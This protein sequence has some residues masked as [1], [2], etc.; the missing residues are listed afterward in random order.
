[1]LDIIRSEF[2]KVRKSKVT[3]VT[4]LCLLGIAGL[5]IAVFLYAKIKGGV[6][7]EMLEGT[8]GLDVYF[9]FANGWKTF[10]HAM[11]YAFS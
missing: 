7:M 2:Y 1:M 9:A 11:D 10:P 3:F 6:W 5:Q 8:R 4:A